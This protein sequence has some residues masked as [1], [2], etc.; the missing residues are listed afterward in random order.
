MRHVTTVTPIVF[1]TTVISP[2][3][4]L[5]VLVMAEA[6]VVVAFCGEQLFVVVG[7]EHHV[8]VNSEGLGPADKTFTHKS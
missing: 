2:F 5:L 3:P 1:Y 7:A 6:F 4:A 8:L